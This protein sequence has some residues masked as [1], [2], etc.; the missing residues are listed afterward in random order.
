MTDLD[1]GTGIEA[2]VGDLLEGEACQLIARD[3]GLLGQAVEGAEQG[4][5]L[6]LE[7]QI[8]SAS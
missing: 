7:F 1:L 4:P 8:L 2:V 3:T 6:A 5:V